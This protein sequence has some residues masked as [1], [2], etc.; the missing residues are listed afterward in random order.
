MAV[1][2]V[3]TAVLIFLGAAPAWAAPTVSVTPNTN[4]VH[5]QTVTVS[6][7]GYGPNQSLAVIQCVQGATDVFDSCSISGFASTT[8]GPAGSETRAYPRGGA[9]IARNETS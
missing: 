7:S 9:T 2:S 4:L 8:A 6:G 1:V 3:A 5:G